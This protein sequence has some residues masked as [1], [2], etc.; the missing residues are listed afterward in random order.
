MSGRDTVW[1]TGE[2]V[3]VVVGNASLEQCLA[4]ALCGKTGKSVRVVTGNGSLEKCRLNAD[5]GHYK[6]CMTYGSVSPTASRSAWQPAK[7]DPSSFQNSLVI[8]SHWVD[9]VL[10]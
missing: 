5:V 9:N 7:T 8:Q 2:S 3:H 6:T 10:L 1:K 4:G